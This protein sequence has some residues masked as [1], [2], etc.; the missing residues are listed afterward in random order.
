MKV[1]EGIEVASDNVMSNGVATSRR[2]LALEPCACG[3]R[4]KSSSGMTW[5]AREADWRWTHTGEALTYD[6]E[7]C[8]DCVALAKHMQNNG[9]WSQRRER[10][11]A[12]LGPLQA[13]GQG[14]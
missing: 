7:P 11:E 6:P 5:Y 3:R 10:V 2:C 8:A 13:G 4:F 1:T 12:L 9:A 14:E